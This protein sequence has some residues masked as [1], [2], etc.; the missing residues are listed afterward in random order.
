MD[1]K[2]HYVYLITDI[3]NNK[4][5]I[6]KHSTNNLE[7]NYCGSGTIIKNIIKNGNK[8][9]LK[10]DIL[11]FCSSEEEAYQRE[12]YY[13]KMY[14]AVEDKNF[15]NLKTGGIKNIKISQETKDKIRK[16]RLKEG[17]WKKEKNPKYNKSSELKGSNNPFFGKK[18]TK[19]TKEKISESRK[20][21][22]HS[23]ETIL[24]I[25]QNNPNSK[26]VQCVETGIIYN[27]IREAARGVGLKSCTEIIRYL[28]GKAQYAGKDKERQIYYHWR[29][30][31]E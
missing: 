5:Y 24:K 11:E 22:H 4:K 30:Y 19:R 20:G 17:A 7:D 15:Y 2:Y 8:N 27:S 28:Q 18:H 23:T 10:K 14:N 1:K 21:M 3:K 6:G 12:E 16:A 13:I 25:K 9:R 29:Y 31:Y 26:K